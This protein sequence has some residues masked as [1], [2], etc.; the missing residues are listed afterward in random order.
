MD[1]KSIVMIVAQI[2]LAA[3][4]TSVGLHASWRDAL[5]TMRNFRLLGRAVLAVNVV[6]PLT[7][8]VICGLLPIPQLM[9][10]GI[11]IM[12]VSPLAPVLSLRL[13]QARVDAS[14]AVGLDVALVLLSVIVVPLTIALL[15]SIFPINASVSPAAVAKLATLSV[16]MPLAVGM[17]VRALTRASVERLAKMLTVLGYLGLGLVVIALLYT[18]AR[19]AVDLIGSGVMIAILVTVLAGVVAGHFLAGSAPA[20]KLAIT[21][22]ATLRHPG[23]AALIAQRNFPNQKV[24]LTI[25]LY[26]LTAVAFSLLYQAWILKRTVAR[27]PLL[28]AEGSTRKPNVRVSNRQS[29]EPHPRPQ[30]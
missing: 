21:L 24:V 19:D 5:R 4:L 14:F 30:H 26:L 12:S 17:L 25:I 10:V 23:L 1:T 29:D 9:K 13:V 18:Q 11:V 7:A 15:S 3:L 8:I 6:V 22:A 27:R 2:S 28:P 16:L 20:D